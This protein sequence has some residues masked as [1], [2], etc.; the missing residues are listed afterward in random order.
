MKAAHFSLI[1]ATT[2]GPV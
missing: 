1:A 2:T